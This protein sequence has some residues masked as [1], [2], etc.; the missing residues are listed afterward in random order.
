MLT[1]TKVKE[2]SVAPLAEGFKAL[3]MS[4][5]RL[6]TSLSAEEAP[7]NQLAAVKWRTWA[8]QWVF[9]DDLILG[10]E[11]RHSLSASASVCQARQISDN[12]LGRSS[13]QRCIRIHNSCCLLV[14]LP[15]SPTWLLSCFL[16]YLFQTS[17]AN[18]Q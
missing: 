11:D 1:C 14:N 12:M 13:V 15:S 7:R 5:A 16:S 9:G 8:Y 6:I 17:S 18:N 4:D 10:W 3:V 2:A